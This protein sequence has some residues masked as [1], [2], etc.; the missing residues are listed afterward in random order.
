ME[1]TKRHIDLERG[2]WGYGDKLIEEWEYKHMEFNFNKYTP[3]KLI[4]LWFASEDRCRQNLNN[5][6]QYTNIYTHTENGKSW[7][8]RTTHTCSHLPFFLFFI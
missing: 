1:R 7:P 3:V 8:S 5:I 6:V 4:G 2:W